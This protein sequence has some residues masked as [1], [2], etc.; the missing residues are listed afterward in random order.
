MRIRK[1]YYHTQ[2]DNQIKQIF[3]GVVVVMPLLLTILRT[4]QD[5]WDVA[6]YF[7]SASL[8]TLLIAKIPFG[9]ALTCSDDAT[10]ITYYEIIFLKF[11]QRQ[12]G[13]FNRVFI[14]QDHQR[15]YC[16][17]IQT[18]SGATLEM[19]K[20]PTLDRAGERLASYKQFFD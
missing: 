8:F 15:Y 13:R 19:E 10:I 5:R 18:E 20:Y 2:T 11:K 9:H 6:Y 7:V 16:L 3:S 17:K 14:E 1:I 4:L 12:W